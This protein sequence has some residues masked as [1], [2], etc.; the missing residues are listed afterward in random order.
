MDHPY[1]I[2]DL[3]CP[4]TPKNGQKISP[5]KNCQNDQ[6]LTSLENLIFGPP[7]PW[8]VENRILEGRFPG[9][10]K[11]LTRFEAKNSQISKSHFRARDLE[12]LFQRG[13]FPPSGFV[14]QELCKNVIFREP[15]KFDFS[16]WQAGLRTNELDKIQNRSAILIFFS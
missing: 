2:R 8:G 5:S 4:R 10:P 3:T 9:V 13:R 15:Q 6:N 1:S 14:L 16:S 11:T 12:I 7:R